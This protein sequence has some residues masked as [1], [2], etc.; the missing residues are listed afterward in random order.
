MNGDSRLN[1]SMTSKSRG[2][3]HVSNAEVEEYNI[4]DMNIEPCAESWRKKLTLAEE[5]FE[6]V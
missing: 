3:A 1:L 4:T 5:S 2:V 6:E